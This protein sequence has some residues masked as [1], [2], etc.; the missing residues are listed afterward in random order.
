MINRKR[1]HL[2]ETIEH[3]KEQWDTIFESKLKNVAK[4]PKFST[5]WDE[6]YYT[7]IKNYL[8]PLILKYKY[9]KILE[10]GSGSGRSS[11]I[12]NKNLDKTLLD[13]SP[14]ALQYARHIA[15]KFKAK[16]VK[17]VIGNIFDMPFNKETFDFVWNMGV[18]EHYKIQDLK[19][20]LSEMMRVTKKNGLV[21]IGVPNL[22]S[23]PI[24]K[25]LILKY[26][27][28]RFFPGYRLDTE[29]FYNKKTLQDLLINVAKKR[30][31]KVEWI[32]SLYFGNPLP[33]EFPKSIINTL[34]KLID[35]LFP[36][37][38]FLILTVCK[39]TK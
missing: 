2:E 24:I 17:Y 3:E 28:K 27:P 25:A 39:L 7:K 6:D 29:H 23:G 8:Y 5:F 19:L 33:T 32:E 20:I 26:L 35:F 30:G 22:Y 34:G 16:K 18:V 14:K 36:K 37:N 11:I 31:R 12:L 38:R 1:K 9:S 15:K 21:A 4:K 10:S 13:I